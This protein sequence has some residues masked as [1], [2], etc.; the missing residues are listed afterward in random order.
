MFFSFF[1]ELREAKVPVSLREYLTLT[2]AMQKRVAAFDIEDFYYLARAALVKDERYLDRFDRVFGHCFKGIETL[3][4][5][6]IAIPDAWLRKIAERR[7]R[8]SW[9]SSSRRTRI[10]F[11]SVRTS[12]ILPSYL[13][14]E[15]LSPFPA[16][17]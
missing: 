7:I 16:V 14:P 10:G 11:F 5:P 6:Q 12:V 8:L 1:V 3:P 2:E 4:D 15:L 9:L 17:S 13:C